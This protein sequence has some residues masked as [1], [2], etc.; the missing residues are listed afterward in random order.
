MESQKLIEVEDPRN[1]KYRIANVL[2]DDMSIETADF[3]IPRTKRVRVQFSGATADDYPLLRLTNTVVELLDSEG[4]A[5]VTLKCT[6]KINFTLS[7]KA[8]E[9]E[10]LD[11]ELRIAAMRVSYPYHRQMI[12]DMTSRLGLRPTFLPAVP[13]DL[14]AIEAAQESSA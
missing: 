8:G 7:P 9:F 13:D 6:F 12:S 4:E 1:M 14:W 3:E 11:D 2:L 10:D 5:V